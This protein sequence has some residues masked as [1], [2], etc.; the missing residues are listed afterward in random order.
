MARHGHQAPILMTKQLYRRYG[1]G[2]GLAAS[3]AVAA[4]VMASKQCGRAVKNDVKEWRRSLH[5]NDYAMASWRVLNGLG[6]RGCRWRNVA[7]KPSRVTE[8]AVRQPK[9]EMT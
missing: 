5:L 9:R 1:G 6:W 3:A 4:Y 8:L 2:N 7:A